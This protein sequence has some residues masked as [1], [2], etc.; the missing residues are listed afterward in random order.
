V[1]AT[2][3]LARRDG[4]DI[5]RWIRHLHADPAAATDPETLGRHCPPDTREA[6]VLASEQ[7]GDPG[8]LLDIR[9]HRPPVSGWRT[10]T[11]RVAQYQPDTDTYLVRW[12][13]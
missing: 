8:D 1:T 13:D 3:P 12:P 10:T 2:L 7:W 9:Y 4:A 11:W 6:I 5:G